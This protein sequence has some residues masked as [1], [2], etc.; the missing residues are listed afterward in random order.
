MTAP[1]WITMV[2][3]VGVPLLTAGFILASQKGAA[4]ATIKAT[5]VSI[6]EM[7]TRI[8]ER[9]REMKEDVRQVSTLAI[10]MDKRLTGVEAVMLDRAKRESR[11]Q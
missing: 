1:E 9:F 2:I 7:E 3:S 4:D 8:Q 11:G 10:D 6:T 5:K